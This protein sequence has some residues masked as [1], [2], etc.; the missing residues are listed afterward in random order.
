MAKNN[1]IETASKETFE[2]NERVIKQLVEMIEKMGILEAQ[3]KKVQFP[4]GSKKLI[5]EVNEELDK[6]K[7]IMSDAERLQK[8]YNTTLRNYNDAQSNTGKKIAEIRDKTRKLNNENKKSL[9]AYG[10]LQLA[11][12]KAEER[13]RNLAAKL[14]HTANETV[15]ARNQV[16]KLRTAIDN[17]NQ[18]IKRF[19]DNV[20]NYPGRLKGATR[21]L[22]SFISAFGLTS[23]IFLFVQILRDGFKSIREFD[24]SMQNLSGILRTNRKDLKDLEEVI[25]S[26]A[27]KSVNTATDV[28]KLAE[29]LITLGKSK[30]EVKQLLEPVNN[31][32]IGLE[33]TGAEA[34]EFLVQTLNAFGK[35]S[36]SA[37][38][39]ADIIATVRTSTSLNFQKMRDS[40]QY[41]TPISKILNKDLA[42]TGAV[43]GILADNGLKAESAGR[44]LAT[45]QQKLAK[46]GKTLSDALAQVNKAVKS[47]KS[48]IEV[49]AIASGLF[50]AQAAKIGVILAENTEE[51]EIN[52]QAI[53]ENSGALDD[54]VNEQLKS[55]DASLLIL[56][57]RWEEYIIRSNQA[58]GYSNRLAKIVNYLSDNLDKVID[59]V[60]DVAQAFLIYK[61][62]LLAS[63]LI[64]RGYTAITFG[65]RIAKIA[66]S[67][68]IKA[69]RIEMQAFNIATKSNP[70]GILMNVVAAGVATWYAFRDGVKASAEALREAREEADKI[71]QAIVAANIALVR[72]QLDRISDEIKNEKKAVAEKIKLVKEEIKGRKDGSKLLSE[73]E[74]ERQKK[75][76]MIAEEIAKSSER[77]GKI[78][79]EKEENNLEKL[80]KR[81]KEEIDERKVLSESIAESNKKV[82]NTPKTKEVVGDLAGTKET[83]K[84]LQSI[85]DDLLKSQDK[86]NTT[87]D[88]GDGSGKSLK[89]R[90][91]LEKQRLQFQLEANKKIIDNEENSLE[92][93]LLANNDYLDTKKK[94]LVLE[95]NF[96]ISTSKGGADEKLRIQEKFEHDK[97]Q[98][99]DKAEKNRDKIFETNFKK[100]LERA[101]ILEG[102]FERRLDEQVTDLRAKLLSQGKSTREIERQTQEFIA[103]ERKKAAIKHLDLLET[104]LKAIATGADQRIAVEEYIAKL[105]AELVEEGIKKELSAEQMRQKIIQKTIQLMQEL[106]NLG[107]ALTERRV[108]KIDSEIEKNNEKYDKLL[109]SERYTEDER[110]ALEDQR[111]AANEQL[112]RKKVQEQRK[113][114]RF[115]KAISL[116]QITINTAEAISEASPKI[117]LMVLAAA[118]GVAQAAVVAATPIPQYAEGKKK[119]DSYR[120]PMLYGE[121]PGRTEVQ[122]SKTG[123]IKGVASSPTIGFTEPGD[124]IFKSLP[125]FQQ[126]ALDNSFM[127]SALMNSGF[128]PPLVKINNSN[129]ASAKEMYGQIKKEVKDGLKA[130]RFN[131]HNEAPKI[132]L[133]RHISLRNRIG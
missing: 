74:E 8:K 98:A 112:E 35:G 46:K 41:I 69:A 87:E 96:E 124:T 16:N 58:G 107:D 71:R 73:V 39:Y 103:E 49:L 7:K 51:M 32:A 91:E 44:L 80:K 64:T 123:K 48:E 19:G 38:E 106:G 84:E 76:E 23:G 83:I 117:P 68:G 20:G 30:D 13:Y 42:Y 12:T 79:T 78:L 57:S 90:F 129:D 61:G 86:L 63:S 15:K 126:Y 108:Q 127:G 11:L 18:P 131:I 75:A 27:G 93:R 24:K 17:I 54:L 3:A 133:D 92:D 102:D 94:L 6:G 130:A 56:K 26:V 99:T 121:V 118:V 25:I 109:D 29:S 60:V 31:L 34:G 36:D 114:A 4:S 1:F 122:M 37:E 5:S 81:V 67:G 28:A 125:D 10:R 45:S 128:L 116:A 97:T 111:E 43:V 100:Q 47:G 82:A 33:T 101:K 95:K 21:A 14:G 22:R 120:G 2:G 89:E 53:R 88:E 50:G 9:S 119:S 40:F 55:L 66:L 113:Q 115:N 110:K 85:L 59:T 132:D 105:R 65:L 70:L 104:E 52:A 77:W 62:L 72:E